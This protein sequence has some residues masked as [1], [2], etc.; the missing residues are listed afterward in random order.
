MLFSMSTI[1]ILCFTKFH[2]SVAQSLDIHGT[3][4]QPYGFLFF[5]LVIS[6]LAGKVQTLI[7]L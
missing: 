4:V 3:E 7:Q 1:T 2:M 6:F 5:F